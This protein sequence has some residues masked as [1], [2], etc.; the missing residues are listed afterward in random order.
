MLIL[1]AAAAAALEK[2]A[3]GGVIDFRPALQRSAFAVYWCSGL[4]AVH[5]HLFTWLL[6][7]VIDP[8]FKQRL[9]PVMVTN[10]ESAYR[11][12]GIPEDEIQRSVEAERGQDTFSF[13]RMVTG[14]AF[15]IILNF[16]IALLIAATVRTKIAPLLKSNTPLE[17][18]KHRYQI[19]TG[20]RQS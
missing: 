5:C 9:L 2:R 15:S 8:P 17:S 7:N 13:G 20:C 19:P 3:N 10:T 1:L 12:F 18:P 14:T 6:L 11:R 4:V 16:L